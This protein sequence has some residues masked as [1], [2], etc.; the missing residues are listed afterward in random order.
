LIRIPWLMQAAVRGETGRA[1]ELGG[2][3]EGVAAG[4]FKETAE[5]G[6]LPAT[7]SGFA[8]SFF[9]MKHLDVEN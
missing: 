7:P 5:A 8:S 1:P 4:A 2:V 9:H 3:L 6:E